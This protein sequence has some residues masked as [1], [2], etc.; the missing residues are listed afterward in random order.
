MIPRNSI[1]LKPGHVFLTTYGVAVIIHV[2]EK[3]T[4]VVE[5][6]SFFKAKL[7]RQAGKSIA[8]SATAF[9]STHSVSSNLT[10]FLM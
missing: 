1:Q 4:G 7:W 9:L 5:D 2:E 6:A 3:E 8:T 10:L